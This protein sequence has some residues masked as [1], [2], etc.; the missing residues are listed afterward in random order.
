M[1]NKIKCVGFI[2]FLLMI[3]AGWSYIIMVSMETKSH[4]EYMK[5]QRDSLEVEYYKLKIDSLK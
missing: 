1:I 5:Y 2:L 3:S 4:R